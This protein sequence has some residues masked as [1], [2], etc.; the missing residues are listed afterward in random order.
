M[1]W[2]ETQHDILTKYTTLYTNEILI[3]LPS[4]EN[5]FPAS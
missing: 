2:R 5:Y 3:F 1:L 4:T